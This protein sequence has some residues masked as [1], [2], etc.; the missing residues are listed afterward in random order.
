M[1]FATYIHLVDE[2]LIT[3][4]FTPGE[5]SFPCFGSHGSIGQTSATAL[6]AH[7]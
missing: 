1:I 6:P 4:I 7:C 5:L 2:G 3:P